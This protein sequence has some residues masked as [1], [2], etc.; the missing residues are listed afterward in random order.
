M[1][2]QTVFNQE[3]TGRDVVMELDRK[4][5]KPAAT[6]VGA[7]PRGE[8]RVLLKAADGT[9]YVITACR[10]EHVRLLYDPIDTGV[11]G[12]LGL[13]PRLLEVYALQPGGTPGAKGQANSLCVGGFPSDPSLP[14]TCEQ[15]PAAGAASAAAKVRGAPKQRAKL[16]SSPTASVDDSGDASTS[17]PTPA[18]AA[19][20]PA[21]ADVDTGFADQLERDQ[22]SDMPL[23]LSLFF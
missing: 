1:C 8:K 15:A 7:P 16:S 11:L 3:E 17:T 10:K 6:E 18:L 2:A 23:G 5:L 19:P 21:A 4:V 20:A 9:D 22:D 12:R 14:C 13:C